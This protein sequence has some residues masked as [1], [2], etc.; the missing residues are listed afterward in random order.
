MPDFRDRWLFLA[1]AAM[2]WISPPEVLRRELHAL[3]DEVGGWTPGHT[4]SKMHAIFRTAREHQAG[5]RVEWDGLAVSPRYK[6]KNETIIEWLEITPEEERRLKTI[7][8][9][10]GRRRH[11]N[12]RLLT[13][14]QS[15]KLTELRDEAHRS[16]GTLRGM[17]CWSG[18]PVRQAPRDFSGRRGPAHSRERGRRFPQCLGFVSA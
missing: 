2:S 13:E 7:L 10:E 14:L 6:F 11:P 17:E 4:D 1:G 18:P 5:K 8:S 16:A 3:A 15:Y 9:D 12:V